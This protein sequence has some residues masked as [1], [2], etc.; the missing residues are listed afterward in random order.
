METKTAGIV[1]RREPGRKTV[2][3]AMPCRPRRSRGGGVN[4]PSALVI[5]EEFS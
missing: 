4:E 1:V 5:R 3:R 2:K